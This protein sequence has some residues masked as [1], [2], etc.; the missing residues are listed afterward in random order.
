MKQ[1]ADHRVSRHAVKS[2]AVERLARKGDAAFNGN[3][4][5]CAPP[6]CFLDQHAT[7]NR[8][9]TPPLRVTNL[10]QEDAARAELLLTS[11]QV[12]AKKHAQQTSLGYGLPDEDNAV[13]QQET[14]RQDVVLDRIGT[15]VETLRIMS[16]E[17]NNELQVQAPEIDA[18]V[19]RTHVAE[20]NLGNLSKAARKI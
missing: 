10:P 13:L 19:E 9:P 8:L 16:V 4:S 15:A 1:E 3:V 17:L 7:F 5:L 14:V 18:L 20:D 11:H 6:L 12:K 2:Q